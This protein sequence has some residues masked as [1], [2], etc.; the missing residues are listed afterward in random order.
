M[1][2]DV[3][4]VGAGGAGLMAACQAARLGCS[5][6]LIEKAPAVGGTTAMAVGSIMASGTSLQ[7]KMHIEDSALDHAEDLASVSERFKIVDN[8]VLRKMMTEQVTEALTFLES[9][10]IVFADPLPQPPHRKPRLHQVIPGARSYVH[11][12]LAACIEAGVVIKTNSKVTRLT[13]NAG[14]VVGV[15]YDSNGESLTLQARR[16]VVLAS[17]DV[18]G[19]IALLAEHCEGN[20]DGIDVLNPYCTGDGHSMAK[21]IGGHIVS[22][23]D[24]NASEVV[25]MRF[26]PPAETNWIQRIP[27]YTFVGQVIKLALKTLPDAWLRPSVLKFLTTALGPDR[28][29]YKGGALLINKNGERFCD[30]LGGTSFHDVGDHQRAVSADGETRAPSLLLA[31]QPDRIAYIVFD[32]RFA[33]KFSSWPNFVSTAP[34]VSYAYI[35]DYRRARP[36]LFHSAPTLKQLA[37]VLGMDPVKIE[38][39]ISLANTKNPDEMTQLIEGPFY[40]LG[41]VKSWLLVTPVGLAVDDKLRVLNSSSQPIAGLYAAGGVGQGGLAITGHGHGLGWAFASGM[42]AGRQVVLSKAE[43]L[44]T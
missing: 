38:A 33:R 29:L 6:I 21:E 26:V 4:V 7:K 10:G 2:I 8:A 28:G 24:F 42:L 39:S 37:G 41:P 31:Q 11:H 12:L 44:E 9:I 1:E 15:E 30:E 3:I 5:V 20:F 17:G 22:R 36:D 23:P 13:M 40:A 43:A 34:G 27:P 19:N 35:D 16:G 32:E 18:A 14:R 25:Q